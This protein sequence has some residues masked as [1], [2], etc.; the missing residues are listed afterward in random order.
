MMSLRDHI[1]YGKY[2]SL[3]KMQLFVHFNLDLDYSSNE[4]RAIIVPFTILRQTVIMNLPVRL[5]LFI[6][7]CEG[8]HATVFGSDQDILGA[9][10]LAIALGYMY[11]TPCGA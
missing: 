5:Q 10:I 11:M 3:R 9:V 8:G 1:L 2:G 4:S 6:V 7:G